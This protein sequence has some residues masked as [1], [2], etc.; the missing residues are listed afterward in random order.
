VNLFQTHS[1]Y[2]QT[3]ARIN[4]EIREKY[5]VLA[6]GLSLFILEFLDLE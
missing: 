4:L 1:T 5:D 6:M 2:T 3:I